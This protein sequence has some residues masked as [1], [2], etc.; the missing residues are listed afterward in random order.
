VAE[1]EDA[2]DLGSSPRKRIGVRFPSLAPFIL[3]KRS[4]DLGE[5]TSEVRIEDVSSVKKKLSFEIPWT[6]VKNEIDSAYTVVGKKAKIKGFRPGKV[7]R[8]ILEVHYRE[9]A[10]GEAISNMVSKSYL[11]AIEKNNIIAIDQPVIDQKGIEA[12]KNFSY[13]ATVE[14]QPV[15]E[16]K[17]YVGIKV[18]K[19]KAEVTE[20]DIEA[21]LD[22]LR[23]MYATLE[24]VKGDRGLENG[25]FAII[26]FEVTV[27]G[28][29]R[30]ELSSKNYMLQMG[31]K[32]FV[33]GFEEQL[34]G[35]KKGDTKDVKLTFPDD[36]EPKDI[37]GKEG[38]YTVALK[39]IR[40]KIVPELDE[41]FIKNF[42]RYESLESLKDDII[43]SIEAEKIAWVESDV[44]RKIVDNL[45]EKNEF[46]VPSM[47][48]E[49]QIYLMTLDAQQRMIRNGMSPDKVMEIGSNL[50]DRFHD[51]ATRMV[52]SS[53]LLDKIAEKEG[54][55]VGE[56]DI[57]EKLKDIATKTSRDYETVKTTYE[58]NNLLDN[59]KNEI[60]ENKALDF[61]VENAEIK[62]AKKKK[63]KKEEEK[64][65]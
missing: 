54:I 32:M 14:I 4:C 58:N 52:K 27:D 11:E 42:E 16:P 26:D 60:Q 56:D 28:T 3:L 45:L 49:R 13:T 51:Q 43:K 50:R 21:R 12:E 61:I 39:Y 57:E 18:E 19:E 1:L 24:D 38:F 5:I 29:V 33:P 22:Q 31:A 64:S 62:V 36:Y 7:P 2:L 48:V 8:K 37:A 30:E 65:K 17:D 47:W 15:V 10:E 35:M 44:R 46:E 25:D 53:L 55:E 9:E 41:E 59:L 20:E 34:E 63:D 23:E 6:D 40:E